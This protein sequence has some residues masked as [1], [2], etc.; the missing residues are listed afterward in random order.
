[1][2]DRAFKDD[3][4]NEKMRRGGSYMRQ[5]T[6]SSFTNTGPSAA[7]RG[8]Q[9]SRTTFCISVSDGRTV[10]P[11]FN[12]LALQQKDSIDGIGGDLFQNPAFSLSPAASQDQPSLEDGLAFISTP[13]RGLPKPKPKPLPF[14]TDDS[15]KKAH[16]FDF[17]SVPSAAELQNVDSNADVK[18]NSNR[19]MAQLSKWG[20]TG[21]S[22]YDGVQSWSKRF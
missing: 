22:G 10:S 5:N 8:L 18:S 12:D 11:I 15:R 14:G 1:M 16:I 13:A 20:K 4:R 17:I 6:A 7:S 2:K 3:L 9:R 19:N 21:K